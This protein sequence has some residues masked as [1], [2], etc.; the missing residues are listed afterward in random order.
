MSQKLIFIFIILNFFASNV[1]SADLRGFDLEKITLSFKDLSVVV[2]RAEDFMFSVNVGGR[3]YEVPLIDL[4]RVEDIDLSS[5]KMKTTYPKQFDSIL[6]I[7]VNEYIIIEFDFGKLYEFELGE[8]D[9][10][11]IFSI[12]NKIYFIFTTDGYVGYNKRIVNQKNKRVELYSNLVKMDET[13][14]EVLPLS[15]INSRTSPHSIP[16][17]N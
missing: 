10:R 4:K 5:I 2:D 15:E 11:F 8:K 1:K 13:L 16:A 12:R 6:E 3:L 7:G 14:D 17:K 9:S